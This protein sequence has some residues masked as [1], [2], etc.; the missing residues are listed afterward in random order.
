MLVTATK[1][2]KKAT[3]TYALLPGAPPKSISMGEHHEYLA[4]FDRD[5]NYK[6]TLD[7]PLAY[8]FVRLAPLSDGKLVALAMDQ[9]NWV[10]H[11]LLLDADGQVVRQIELPD[12][13]LNSPDLQSGGS[14]FEH[15]HARALTSLSWW[16]FVPARKKVLLYQ[17]HSRSPVLEV[18]D[19]GAVRE[20]SLSAPTGYLL[21]GV[22]SS[23][24]RWIV[25]YKKEDGAGAGEASPISQAPPYAVFDV[26]ANDGSLRSKLE[27]GP[28]QLFGIACE[29]D[30]VFTAFTLNGDKPI[31]QTADIPR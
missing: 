5:G 3:G 10:P 19:G 26:D 2:D 11:L 23:N 18:G 29:Q 31:R 12:A 9:I 25:R 27:I 30:G 8:N 22:I 7:L 4:L 15:D 24:D 16:L 20:V 21:D 14:S 1:D 13:M 17:A 6:E 28:G